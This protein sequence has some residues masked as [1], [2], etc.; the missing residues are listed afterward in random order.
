MQFMEIYDQYYRRL[1]RFILQTVRNEWVADDL[2]QE[3]FIRVK[4]NLENVRDASKLQAWLF[5]IAYNLCQ[6]YFRRQ[7]K[8]S[9]SDHSDLPPRRRPARSRRFR[10]NWNNSR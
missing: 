10:K 9:S 5:R 2:V 3:T 6:D 1:R 4:N 8:P 7:G